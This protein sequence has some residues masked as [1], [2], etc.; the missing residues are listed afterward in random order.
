[1]SLTP[2]LSP[3]SSLKTAIIINN[4]NKQDFLAGQSNH[5]INNSALSLADQIKLN[6]LNLLPGD[7]NYPDVSVSND[8]NFFLNQIEYWSNLSFLNRIIV[9]LK[10]DISAEALYDH[11]SSLLSPFPYIKITLQDNLLSRSKSFDNL[12]SQDQNLDVTKSLA[13]FKS[14]H[15]GNR[16][17]NYHYN[18]PTPQPGGI[19]KDDTNEIE[20]E[21]VSVSPIGRRRSVTKTLFTPKL[22]LDTSPPKF[23]P[24]IPQSPTITLD[25]TF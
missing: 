4:L 11:L 23:A 13:N 8:A 24:K 15:S 25:E 5:I 12:M 14:I 10:E 3:S 17:K 21:E 6:I 19:D 1:M 20:I 16:E 2:P 18:E 7:I 9:I 22:G